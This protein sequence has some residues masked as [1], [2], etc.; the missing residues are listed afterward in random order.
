MCRSEPPFRCHIE[1]CTRK[2]PFD[3]LE[4]LRRHLSIVHGICS[5][6]RYYLI[7]WGYIEENEEDI[8]EEKTFLEKILK[9]L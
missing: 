9:V 1:E 3:R 2:A 7:K 8:E 4:D 6:Q 5:G